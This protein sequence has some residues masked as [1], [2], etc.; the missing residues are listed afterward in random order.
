M[1]PRGGLL[2]A[3]QHGVAGEWARVRGTVLSLWPLFLSFA[4][5]GAFLSALA[6]GSHPVPFAALFVASLISVFAYWRKGLRRIE[7]FFMGARGEER[8]ASVL[9]T[10]PE[11]FHVFHDFVAGGEHVDHVVAG[12]TGVF[13]VE[14]KNWRGSVRVA[15]G[16]VLAN[17]ALP[18]RDPVAQA[19]REAGRVREKLRRMGFDVT[20]APVVCFATDSLEGGVVECGPARLMNASDAPAW[21]AGQAECVAESD[22]ARMVQLMETER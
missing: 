5:L 19:Q 4:L 18:S 8:V 16:R 20:V 17:G 7:S 22:L 15:E 10:L 6:M 3:V 2:M 9:G 21:M 13:S 11:E 1:I 14:T 12:P